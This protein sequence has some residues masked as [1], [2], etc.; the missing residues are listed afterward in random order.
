MDFLRKIRVYF[1]QRY[2]TAESFKLIRNK[3]PVNLSNA[4]TIGIIYHLQSEDDYNMVSVFTRQLQEQGK[5]VWVIG[6]YDSKRIPA[7]YIPKLS[8][9]LILPKDIDFIFRPKG[10]FVTEFI[11]TEFSMLIDLSSPDNFTLS[12]IATLSKANFK[13]G[14]TIDDRTLPY[15]IMI[16]TPAEIDYQELINQIIYYFNNLKFNQPENQE[17]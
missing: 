4:S 12:Y 15:D 9:D 13:L 8:Y 16:D 2:L 7:Y 1:G 5:K 10:K 11:D 6:L 3:K 14:R 17:R